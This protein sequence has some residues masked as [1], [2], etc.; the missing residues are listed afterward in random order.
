MALW[1]NTGLFMLKLKDK[2][3]IVYVHVE[4]AYGGVQVYLHSFL[5]SALCGK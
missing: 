5:K 3:K 4:K 1:L 2:R